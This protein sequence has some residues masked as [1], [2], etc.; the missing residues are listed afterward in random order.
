MSKREQLEE[1]HDFFSKFY[2]LSRFVAIKADKITWVKDI[3]EATNEYVELIQDFEELQRTW[4]HRPILL[5]GLVKQ[6]ALDDMPIFRSG[7][8]EEDNR[9]R[10]RTMRALP[11]NL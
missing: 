5:S 10:K 8:D 4:R 9:R 7:F 2:R 6:P 11:I 3:E 1:M